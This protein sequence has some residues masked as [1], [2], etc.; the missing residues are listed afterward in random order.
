MVR[1]FKKRAENRLVDTALPK[2]AGKYADGKGLW[3][4]VTP[5]GSRSWVFRYK[6][7]LREPEKAE[8]F[9]GLGSYPAVSLVAAREKAQQARED[10][11]RGEDPLTAN[12]RRAA[13]QMRATEGQ[14]VIRRS[15]KEYA[16]L[17][18]DAK[19]A[20]WR[21]EK[22]KDQWEQSLK[23]YVY[24]IIGPV[25]VGD[26]TIQ[27]VLDV[28]NPP[29]DGGRS[30]WLERPVTASRVRGRIESIYNLARSAA[31]KAGLSLGDNPADWAVLKEDLPQ[32][33]L[34]RDVEHYAALSYRD[35]P[36]FMAALREQKGI[37]ALAFQFLILTASRTD[38]VL[39]ARWSEIDKAAR[40]WT[41]PKGRSKSRSRRNVKDQRK[42]L[43]EAALAILETVKDQ[44]KEFV[45]PGRKGVALSENAIRRVRD[46]M[47][48][49]KVMTPTGPETVTPHGMRSTFKDWAGETTNHAN[50]AIELAQGHTVGNEAERAY[51]RGDMLEKRFLLAEDWA[52]YCMTAPSNRTDTV[53]AFGKRER[54]AAGT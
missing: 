54:Q 38:E 26:L 4:Y 32:A 22:H 37:A 48:W 52:Q 46:R 10:I 43:S 5:R 47:K 23:D 12:E 13:E 15:F 42:P 11:A 6:P 35:M 45:F 30:L 8:G 29:S 31:L 44:D 21:N 3:L 50:Y 2:K 34:V 24:P 17:R 51:M 7:N 1:H 28:L 18:M 53:E 36:A 40:V 41:I 49:P 14:A 9:M 19:S 20:E 16:K 39:G 27:H 33:S 25:P